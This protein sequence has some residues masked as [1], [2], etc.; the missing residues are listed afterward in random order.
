V[1]QQ[2][3]RKSKVK[4]VEQ[5]TDMEN[6]LSSVSFPSHG[7]VY[8]KD[9]LRSLAGVAD[10]IS[11]D[12]VP[13]EALSRFTIGQLTSAE[14]WEGNRGEMDLDR[15]PCMNTTNTPTRSGS[16]TFPHQGETQVTTLGRWDGMRLLGFGSMPF[17]D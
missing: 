10:D 5:I 12:G 11:A 16:L 8:L 6:T 13:D 3:P 14:L 4:M 2:W 9:D 15:G 1:W 17:H 7:S